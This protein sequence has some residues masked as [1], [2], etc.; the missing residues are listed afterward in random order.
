MIRINNKKGYSAFML[1]IIMALIIIMVLILIF[2]KIVPLMKGASESKLCQYNLFVTSATKTPFI[3]NINIP[4]E[5]QMKRTTLF[6]DELADDKS[7]AIKEIVNHNKKFKD[8]PEYKLNYN[9]DSSSDDWLLYLMDKAVAK[10]LKTCWETGWQGNFNFFDEWWRF[11]TPFWDD[12]EDIPDEDTLL[13]AFGNKF[14]I[15]PRNCIACARIKFD[16]TIQTKFRAKTLKSVNEWMMKTALPA[17]PDQRSYWEYTLPEQQLESIYRKGERFS[18]D[19]D[20]PYLVAF[21]RVNVHRG[22][23]ITRDIGD[24]F[25]FYDESMHPRDISSL[26]LIPYD[27]VND[28]CTFIIG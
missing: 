4:P 2:G 18:Y 24:I 7:K 17:D 26:L 3:Q 19:V 27:E 12:T 21:V 5:C 9:I 8:K 25:P 14:H 23:E 16:E 1:G 20:K 28:Y 6:Y 22:A 13:E 11:Y 15:A 10:E